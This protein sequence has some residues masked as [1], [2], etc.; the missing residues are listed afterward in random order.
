[1]GLAGVY[2]RFIVCSNVRHH[3]HFSGFLMLE[4]DARAQVAVRK[5]GRTSSA[6]LAVNI[7][8]TIATVAATFYPGVD[9]S[10]LGF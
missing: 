4:A 1:M 8:L 9:L 3:R 2:K 7:Q 6:V 5:A 10:F